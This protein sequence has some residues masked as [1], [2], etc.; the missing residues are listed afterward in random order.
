MPTPNTIPTPT[1]TPTPTMTMLQLSVHPQI[2]YD[3]MI[4]N[5]LNHLF[6]FVDETEGGC[7]SHI[8]F[9][10][11]RCHGIEVL[12]C[13]MGATARRTLLAS[14]VDSRSEVHRFLILFEVQTMLQQRQQGH[15][16]PQDAAEDVLEAHLG[17][18]RAS[19]SR[20]LRA[21][22]GQ[23][24]ALLVSQQSASRS[25]FECGRWA[26]CMGGCTV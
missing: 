11:T 3:T 26:F 19:L 7:L 6:L 22:L 14:L 17:Q 2:G 9:K 16:S 24:R 12:F 10:A 1:P 18:R 25:P 13:S 15:A 21:S 8:F 4:F 5:W 20:Q 23:R